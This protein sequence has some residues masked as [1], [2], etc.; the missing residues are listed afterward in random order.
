M[1]KNKHKLTNDIHNK[2]KLCCNEIPAMAMHDPVTNKPMLKKV[3]RWIKGSELPEDMRKQIEDFDSE[4]KYLQEGRQEVLIN[5][6]VKLIEAYN[7]DGEEGI[8]R[9]IEM[10]N[11][12]IETHNKKQEGVN[13]LKKAFMPPSQPTTTQEIPL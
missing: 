11:E 13:V 7:S 2:I 8:C 6:E 5:H 10:V 9:Y 1:K 4:E 3:R 12:V